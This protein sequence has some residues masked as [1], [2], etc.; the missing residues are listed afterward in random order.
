MSFVV[1]SDYLTNF[2][3]IFCPRADDQE[4]LVHLS[5]VRR[6]QPNSNTFVFRYAAIRLLEVEIY[7]D[8]RLVSLSLA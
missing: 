1:L 8:R 5:A 6:L 4:P 7:L 2:Y 3:Q